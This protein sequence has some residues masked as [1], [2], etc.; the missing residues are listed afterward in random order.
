MALK[1]LQQPLV[2]CTQ[3]K[4]IMQTVDQKLSNSVTLCD[5]IRG[6]PT[7]HESR[8]AVCSSIKK[9]IKKPTYKKITS[10]DEHNIWQCDQNMIFFSEKKKLSQQE[11][12]FSTNSLL[13][14]SSAKASR[15]RKNVQLCYSPI[16]EDRPFGLW[17][18]RGTGS[19]THHSYQTFLP[20]FIRQ[21][22]T[23]N[24]SPWLRYSGSYIKQTL[25]LDY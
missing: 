11:F 25:T 14:L 1:T 3:M 18:G 24:L 22:W 15:C 23:T 4:T 10:H 20:L 7:K 19:L 2:S 17:T 12:W 5:D 21:K 13:S 9:L 16:V 6:W 8:I